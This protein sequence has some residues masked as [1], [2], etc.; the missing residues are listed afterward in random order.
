MA[1]CP[2]S[3]PS[4]VSAAPSRHEVGRR[5]QGLAARLDAVA[6][7]LRLGRRETPQR[8]IP[9]ARACIAEPAKADGLVRFLVNDVLAEAVADESC[10]AAVREL[11]DRVRCAV[12]RPSTDRT[13]SIVALGPAILAAA[14]RRHHRRSVHGHGWIA[15]DRR[16][17]FLRAMLDDATGRSG[18]P[19]GN[20]YALWLAAAYAM[21]EYEVDHFETRGPVVEA[22]VRRLARCAEAL[23][24]PA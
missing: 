2:A 5:R 10:A 9:L 13:H 20:W 23:F 16:L 6:E 1:G 15:P 8:F 17:L 12:E 22:R 3:D 19:S 14:P 4:V 24:G 11:L 21:S 7:N 18:R